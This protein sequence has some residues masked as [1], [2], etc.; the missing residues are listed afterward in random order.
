MLKRIGVPVVCL[1]LI[2]AAV[3]WNFGLQHWLAYATGSYNCPKTGCPGG[4]AHNYNFF[5]GSGSDIG[6]ITLVSIAIAAFATWW[7]KINCHVDGC[8]RIGK[9]DKAGG[10]YS[11][12][13]KHHNEI[14][15]NPVGH[16]F[17]IHHIRT[18]HH[19]HLHGHKA[20]VGSSSEGAPTEHNG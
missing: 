5:S 9:H 15:G 12:C 4:V 13:R 16:K 14:D 20:P 2:A 1:L 19:E 18:K 8:W 6:E 11:V 17:S 10:E 3:F 7:H